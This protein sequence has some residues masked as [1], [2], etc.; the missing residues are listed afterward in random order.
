MFE[1]LTS[2]QI[3][4]LIQGALVIVAALTITAA[5][6]RVLRAEPPRRTRYLLA[7]LACAALL[8]GLAIYLDR[9]VGI[10]GRGDM[11]LNV[12]GAGV[13]AAAGLAIAGW[14]TRRPAWGRHRRWLAI[15]SLVAIE[16]AVA[17]AA[18]SLR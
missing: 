11:M 2:T 12:I 14:W 13:L 16:A 17:A 7:W 4:L 3:A 18:L 10:T 15:L 5:E 6:L 9:M 8:A 1:R